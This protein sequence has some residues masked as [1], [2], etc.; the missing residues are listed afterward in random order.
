MHSRPSPQQRASVLPSKMEGSLFGFLLSDY[1]LSS[2]D[3]LPE[4]RRGLAAV[5]V[6][7]GA[8]WQMHLHS[9]DSC[10]EHLCPRWSEQRASAAHGEGRDLAGTGE[11]LTFP[12]ASY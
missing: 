9:C 1:T 2:A 12:F 3:S 10:T 5:H 4:P 8:G 6:S 11:R 7:A